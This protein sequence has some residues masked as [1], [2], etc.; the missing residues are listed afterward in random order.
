MDDLRMKM[1][2]GQNKLEELMHKIPGFSGYLDRENRREADSIQREFLAR[3]L[4]E[5]KGKIQEA[6]ADMLSAGNLDVM[7]PF[8]SVN[9]KLDRVIE[10][11]RHASRGYSGFFDAVKVNEAE[12]DRIYDFDLALVSGISAAEEALMAV[13]ATADQEGD[14]KPVLRA[15]TTR[16]TELDS[17]LDERDRVLKG[18][19]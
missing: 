10:R 4:T 2:A 1:E 19:G 12:L 3:R 7:E 16:V 13:T 14:L 5:L 18:V 6:Q 8:D 17:S 11:I 9:N 15:L